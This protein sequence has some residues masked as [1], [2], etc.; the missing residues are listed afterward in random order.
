MQ[1]TRSSFTHRGFE[2]SYLDSAPKDN[3]RPVVLLLHGFPDSA[4]M[5]QPQIEALHAEGYR[6]IA[7]DTLGNGYSDIAPK[8]KDYNAISIAGDHRALLDHLG[9]QKASVVGHDWGAAVAWLVA[10]YHPEYVEK[11]VVISVG[12]PTAYARG[13]WRQKVLGWYTFFFQLRGISELLI[14]QA[15][16]GR[17]LFKKLE[18]FQMHP[19]LNEVAERMNAPGR[20][21]A[22]INIY[23]AAA[24]S[25]LFQ[26]QP[27][28]S[29][30]TLGI[31]SDGDLFLVESQ[32]TESEQYVN[33]PWRYERLSGGHWLP[34]EQPERISQLI[35]EHLQ[36]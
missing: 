34:I 22:G 32:M 15:V 17:R 7:P 5:W 31:W 25:L 19:D 28:V 13:E 4:E 9:I 1:L 30:P 35:I 11:L 10:A 18:I 2:L 33:G 27:P 14:K 16:N 6:C 21:T 20:L 3:K 24:T 8:V 23:R 26:A 36:T 29:C 12:H